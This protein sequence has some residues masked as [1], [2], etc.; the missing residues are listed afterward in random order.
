MSIWEI[1]TTSETKEEEVNIAF[2][3]GEKADGVVVWSE[4]S[5]DSES[6]RQEAAI[7]IEGGKTMFFF[8]DEVETAAFK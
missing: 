2:K 1:I 7:R 4:G 3:D 6:G 8:V 5:N